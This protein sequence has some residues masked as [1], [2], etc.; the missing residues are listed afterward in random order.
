MQFDTGVKGKL[1]LIHSDRRQFIIRAKNSRIYKLRI[2]RLMKR[3]KHSG[4]NVI[5]SG[6]VKN[7]IIPNSLYYMLYEK[8][9]FVYDSVSMIIDQ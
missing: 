6:Q 3:W 4:G 1:F 7:L 2:K 9:R 5:Q 8:P